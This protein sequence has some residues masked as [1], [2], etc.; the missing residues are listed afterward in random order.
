MGWNALS[1]PSNVEGKNN[2]RFARSSRMLLL[3]SGARSTRATNFSG[4]GSNLRHPW[5]RTERTCCKNGPN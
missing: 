4:L 5:A 1:E 3:R 2:C